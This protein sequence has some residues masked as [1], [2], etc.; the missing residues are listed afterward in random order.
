[1]SRVARV[2]AGVSFPS[3]QP[4]ARPFSWTRWS[5]VTVT[6]I[7]MAMVVRGFWPSYFG[8]L[9]K[10]GLSRPWIIH[11]HGAIFSGWMLLL[12]AQVSLVSAR[13]VGMHRRLGAVGV[14]YG[15]LVLTIGLVVSFVAPVLHVRAGEWTR[16]R[17]AGFL[18]LP[19]VDMV[20]FA[21]FFGAAIAYRKRPEIHKRLILAATVA[22]AFAAVARMSF[23]S[24]VVFLLV[25][26]SPLLVAM[27]FDVF[28]RQRVHPVHFINMAIMAVAF[29]R[30][31]F[32]E[33]EGWLKVGRAL[34]ALFV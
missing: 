11:L 28:S 19:L 13:R 4:V 10:G 16:D 23:E 21:G 12:L 1:M 24:P 26:L 27:A 14:V 34:L 2:A 15:A 17:A 33:S 25:W 32:M 30:I 3:G 22:L 18:L 5:Y 20:L 6:L 29:V 8:P 7:L 31:F 9:L